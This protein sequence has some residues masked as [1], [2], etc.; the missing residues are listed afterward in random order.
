VWCASAAP[1]CNV[2]V[3]RY[4]LEHWRADP[5]QVILFHD[6]PLSE[7]E[8]ALIRTL[9]V[10]QDQALAN[11][12]VRTRDVKK[13]EGADLEIFAA[14]KTPELPWLVVRYPEHLGITT[15][16]WAGRLDKVSIAALTASPVRQELIRRL[17]EGQTAVW[18]LLECGEAEKDNAA[19]ARIEEELKNLEQT[20]PLPELS[21][22][23]E[24]QLLAGVPLKVA[25]SL[26]RVSR[27]DAAEQAL[28]AMLLHSEPDL[29]ERSDP[30]VFPVFGRGRALLPLV[31]AGI[32]A[33]NIHDAAVFLVGPCSCQVKELNPGFDLLLTDEWAVLISQD[34]TAITRVGDPPSPQEKPELV[35]IPAGSPPA[36][37][38]APQMTAHQAFVIWTRKLWI[39]AGV[40][41]AGL[42]LVIGLVAMA[43][44]TGA[45]RSDERAR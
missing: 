32:T 27:G 25:F 23:P 18:L 41:L 2:P 20:L 31:G 12:T 19:A 6:Q 7:A 42:L 11:L 15:P 39:V 22:A 34:E 13:L 21:A 45:R 4:A 36:V 43:I 1:A 17:T 3:F 8:Q 40:A 14:Q 26:L 44:N 16:V 30:M 33:E 5:Y 35:P 24:D 28:V 37:V 29:A 10:Q 38:S 9:E